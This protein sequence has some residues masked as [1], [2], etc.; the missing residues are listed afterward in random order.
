MSAERVADPQ[1]VTVDEFWDL[2]ADGQK[3]DLIDG[4]IYMASPDSRPNNLLTNFILF[5]LDGYVSERELGEVYAQRFA[6]V[7]SDRRAPEPDVA[8]VSTARLDIVDRTRA[9]GGPDIAVEVTAEESRERDT[10]DK[11]RLYGE[12]GVREYWLTDA[13]R[14]TAEFNVLFGNAY[15]PA[16]LIEGHFFRSEALPGFWLDVDWLFQCPLPNKN[17]CLTEILAGDPGV[18]G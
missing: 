15:Q 14:G 2:V 6:F 7:L 3:A 16:A 8:Y 17:S 10:V 1:D 11:R 5:L 9:R 4:V 18:I 12:A 13:A